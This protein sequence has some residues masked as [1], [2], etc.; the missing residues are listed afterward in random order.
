MKQ[1]YSTMTQDWSY[2]HFIAYIFLSIASSDYSLDTEEVAIINEKINRTVQDIEKTKSIVAEVL[3]IVEK[4]SD[5]EK[6]AYINENTSKYLP[7]V[8]LRDQVRADMEDVIVADDNVDSTEMVM[9]RFVK[10]A[11]RTAK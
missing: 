1:N 9:F 7:T 2:E 8:E 5:E 4:Q 11:L 6:T 10:Q 3:S